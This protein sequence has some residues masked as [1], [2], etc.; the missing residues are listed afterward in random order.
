VLE[1]LAT[2][3]VLYTDAELS[4]NLYTMIC[5][6]ISSLNRRQQVLSPSSLIPNAH[7]LEDIPRACCFL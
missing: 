5:L 3:A 7:A 2:A 1:G 4:A 6:L